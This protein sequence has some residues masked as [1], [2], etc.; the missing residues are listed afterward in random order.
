MIDNIQSIRTMLD[1]SDPDKFYMLEILMR[2]KDNPDLFKDAIQIACYRV[3]KF[4]KLVT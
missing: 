4:G 3:R 2:R 1:F